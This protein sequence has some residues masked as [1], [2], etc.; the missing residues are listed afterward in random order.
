ME[1]INAPINSR[2]SEAGLL[3]VLVTLAENVKLLIIGPL[4]IGL[5]AL[6]IGFML[7]E[8]YQSVAVVQ[9]EQPTA[10][11]MTTAVV[12]DPVIASL[13]L[14]KDRAVEE[15]RAKL[16]QQIKTTVGRTDKLLTLNVSAPSAQD[17]QIIAAAILRQTFKESRPK[18]TV[19][20]R[21]E[22]QL[23]E[24]RLRFSN[25]QDAGAGLLKRLE[26]PS[27]GVSGGSELARGYAELLSAT[28]TAQNQIS[29]LEAQLEGLSE[30]QLVQPPTLPQKPTHPKKALIAIGAAL[31]TGL[32]LLL[33]VLVRQAL[34]K[35][36]L[37]EATTSKIKRIRRSLGLK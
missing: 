16:R 35:T 17:S 24:A 34:R 12:L 22:T 8:T 21:L 14:A 5:C 27:S 30:A 29:T 1:E 33:F 13:G 7:P 36:A 11:L 2:E 15:A 37:N 20:S 9:A 10:S 25:A 23:A 31:A 3:D 32:A 26:S 6:G 19:R 28:G 4:L 18:G